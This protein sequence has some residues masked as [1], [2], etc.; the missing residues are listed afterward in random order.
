MSAERNTPD[1][2]DAPEER[3]RAEGITVRD[4]VSAPDAEGRPRRSNHSSNGTSATAITSAAVTGRKNSAPSRNAKG[5]ATIRPMLA[6]SVREASRRSRLIVSPSTSS[7]A[8]G[9]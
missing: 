9:L 3:E 1:A 4:P 5:N 6:T 8:S 7:T 2:P